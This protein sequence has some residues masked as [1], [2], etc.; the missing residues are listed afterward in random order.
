[1][2]A[3]LTESLR[4]VLLPITTPF[5]LSGGLDARALESN[6]KKW[7]TTGI[8]GYA[9]LGST[10]ERVNLDE[11]EYLQVI[12]TA[13]EAVPP[14]LA[15]IVGAGQQS[16][17][18][19]INEVKRAA[20]SGADAVLVLTPFFYRPAI[21]QQALVTHYLAVAD[22]A[23][24]PVILYSMPALTGIKIE[25]QTIA[26]LSSH[27]NIIGVKDS[28]AD[29]EGLRE[30]V[31]LVG[32]RAHD[33]S[34]SAKDFAILTG[35]GTVLCEALQAGAVGGILAVGCV[36]SELCLQILGAVKQGENDAARSMQEKLTPLAQAVTSKYGI[37]GLKAALDLI[38][39]QGGAV[40]APLAAP[41]EAARAEILELLENAGVEVGAR[42]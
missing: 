5:D 16:T 10:G 39:Y 37:G 25:P 38:G 19:T 13:R 29:I 35:N 22:E 6:L 12:E 27:P 31:K 32:S 26:E 21:T 15:F 9:V 7:Q 2:T 34:H 23:P 24:V 40:R 36:A 20:A 4:G 8:A 18:G 33:L 17:R 1:M 41:G 3:L 42:V 28:S 14:E 11:S 30:T